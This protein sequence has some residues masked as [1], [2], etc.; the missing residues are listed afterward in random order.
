MNSYIKRNFN[1]LLPVFYFIFKKYPIL[2][3]KP[4]LLQTSYF[5]SYNLNIYKKLVDTNN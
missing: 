4:I 2:D 1:D 5:M 3:R